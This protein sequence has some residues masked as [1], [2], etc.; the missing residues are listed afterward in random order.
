MRGDR[1]LNPHLV[2]DDNLEI[3]FRHDLHLF[4]FNFRKEFDQDKLDILIKT[5]IH[6]RPNYS[7]VHFKELLDKYS[8]EEVLGGGQEI[9][10]RD[11]VKGENMMLTLS[12]WR[13]EI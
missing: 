10:V 9:K 12:K 6:E 13:G 8:R 2:V 3:R 4:I 11:W 5:M 7:L 1:R